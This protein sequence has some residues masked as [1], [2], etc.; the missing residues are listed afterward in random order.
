[1]LGRLLTATAVTAALL[2]AAPAVAAPVS[3]HAQL[4]ACCT[5]YEMKD[6][7]FAEAA[8]SG[9]EY[10]RVDVEMSSIFERFGQPSTPDWTGLDEVMELARRHRV[11]VLGVILVTPSH[12]STCPERWPDAGRCPAADPLRYGE[13]AG[14]IA[15][16]ARDH[17]RHWEIVNEPDG[18][19]AFEGSAEDYARMLSASYDAIKARV[20]EAQLVMGGLMRPHVPD[21]LERVFATPGADAVH[22][23]DIANAHLRGPAAVLAPRLERFR[24]QLAGHGF[25]GPVWVTEHGY[26]ADPAFQRD[27]AFAG[28]EPGQAG[29]LTQ[30][31][32]SLAEAGA[33]QVFVTLRDNLAGEY[34]SEGIIRI[35]ESQPG[36]PATRRPAFAAVRR[37][38]TRWE[39]LLAMRAEQRGH[40]QLRQLNQSLALVSARN[41]KVMRQ[42]LK[43]ARAAIAA[44]CRKL[45]PLR[46]RW[47]KRVDRY[48]LELG[49]ETAM[50][51]HYRE[52]ASLHNLAALDL[53]RR[54]A[55]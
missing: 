17:I 53:A 7:I 31:L 29:Y 1:M 36:Y 19:W 13:L 21:W 2:G 23:F 32:L 8:A 46:C 50:G 55:G 20:P 41:R 10:V 49:W 39:E 12:I 45:P 22:K 4:Y 26:P 14:E 27:P 38:A 48:R 43:Y 25:G 42:R 35:D 52:R 6:R 11:R 3:S 30:S 5:P 33:E 37:V 40:E 34:A 24:A 28:G 18:E 16:H 15:H 51:R 9:A 44:K 54:V 47:R